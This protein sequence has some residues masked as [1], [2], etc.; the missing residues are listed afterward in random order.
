MPYGVCYLRRLFSGISTSSI[1]PIIDELLILGTKKVASMTLSEIEK[2]LKD[3]TF[4]ILFEILAW[5]AFFVSC[6]SE[7]D[8][9]MGNLRRT[10]Y[11]GSIFF[12]FFLLLTNSKKKLSVKE[13]LLQINSALIL[14]LKILFPSIFLFLPALSPPS[15]PLSLLAY[16]P[17]P[18]FCTSLTPLFPLSLFSLSPLFSLTLSLK[19]VV[20][21]CVSRQA[22]IF[23]YFS[24]C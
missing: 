19:I 1:S 4:N 24:E 6:S 16:P 5:E 12:A 8:M 11:L 21:I 20:G 14:S 18:F 2:N 22:C 15:L 9:M 10:K 23:F 7:R 3:D 13:K 17:L